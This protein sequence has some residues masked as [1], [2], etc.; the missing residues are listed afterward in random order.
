MTKTASDSEGFLGQI[1]D[2]IAA[3]SNFTAMSEL[4]SL[5]QPEQYIGDLISLDYDSAEVLIHDSHR[6][7]VNGLPYGCL[8]VAS[9]VTPSAPPLTDPQDGR[10][11]LLLL[12]VAGSVRLN[13][14]IDLNRTRFEI[15]QRS[16]DTE[17]NYDDSQQTDQ[18]TLNLL[19]YSGV[20]CRILGTFRTY[21]TEP[22]AERQLYFG[23]DI[24]NFYA[25]QGMKIYKPNGDAL[26]KIVNYRDSRQSPMTNKRVGRL[27]YSAAIREDDTPESV[28]IEI[29]AEDFIAQRTALF[30]MT[31]TGKS[32]TT[33][34]IAS[35]LFKLREGQRPIR[36]GQL[37]F[38]PNGEYANDNPQDQGCIRNLK[39]ERQEYSDEVHTYGSFPHPYDPD[40]HIT[41]FN[42][43]GQPEPNSPPTDKTLLN[44]QLRTL[45]QGKQIIDDALAEETGGYITA[46]CNVDLATGAD[47][48]DHGEYTRFRR[49]LFVYR[50]I[51]AETGFEYSGHANVRGLFSKCLRDL[52][53]ESED[54]RQY[55]DLLQTG[56]M[57]WEVAGN[58]TK[59]FAGWI[60]EQAFRNFDIEYAAGH[61]GRNWSDAHLL[62]LLRYYDNTRARAITQTTRVWHDLDSTGDYADKI[63]TQV[64]QGKL[65][66]VDQLLGDPEL[67][68]Q[69]AE[70]ITRRL[71]EE[72]QR[73]F[74]QPK[75]DETTRKIVPPPPVVVYAEEAH[76]LLPRA[77]E[78]D[79]NNIWARIAKEGAKFN[80]GVVYSTQEPSSIQTNILKNTEN[81]FIAHLNNTDETSQLSKYK[82]FA[83][84][85]QS[86]INVEEAGLIKVRTASGKFTVP[87][88]M[89]LFTS[90]V[91]D[92]RVVQATE[93]T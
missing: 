81:W 55:V 67:N 7:R 28:P 15:V 18:F 86:I 23:A 42:F 12:R 61:G 76:T 2:D 9:R 73:T 44:N 64:R 8:L 85:A 35:A 14:D 66:I 56:N 24:A 47:S 26:Q 29:T 17:K 6:T 92:Q 21:Q 79:T 48:N 33:K 37:I 83:D 43:Y 52:M 27:R 78:D 91:P 1:S 20:K 58:F 70:R 53:S 62:G 93:N 71:F 68:Q 45:Y 82:D 3:D 16:N 84:F 4:A 34:T 11:S 60:K 22:N 77:N 57:E 69:A 40:R 41:K 50:S 65:V 72:Q 59:A 80:I 46:F 38:D 74:S 39:Y 49:R 32:N 75:I 5:I 51:L 19:R 87:V 88:Q 13:S 25:G 30:G 63:V 31:R 54:I 36:V 89:D 10:A 90:P